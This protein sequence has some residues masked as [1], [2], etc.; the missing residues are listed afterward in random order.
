MT[1]DVFDGAFGIVVKPVLTV[2][3]ILLFGAGAGAIF[4]RGQRPGSGIVGPIANGRI[5]VRRSDGR[6]IGGR[7]R[8]TV[9]R[10]VQSKHVADVDRLRECNSTST[11]KKYPSK[12]IRTPVHNGRTL[13]DGDERENTRH[14]AATMMPTDGGGSSDIIIISIL[15]HYDIDNC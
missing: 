15:S 12:T 13:S 2:V 10:Y 4:R 5:D 11:K 1:Q 8:V 9:R 7:E 14:R 6:R 3:R